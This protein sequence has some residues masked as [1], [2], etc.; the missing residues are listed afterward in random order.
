MTSWVSVSLGMKASLGVRHRESRSASTPEGPADGS[1]RGG[2][3]PDSIKGAP[4]V[5]TNPCFVGLE[6]PVLS[7]RIIGVARGIA[8]A[9]DGDDRRGL[10][11]SG[12]VP[13]RPLLPVHS[14][15]AGLMVLS[16]MVFSCLEWGSINP[17]LNTGQAHPVTA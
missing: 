15:P 12:D 16:A 3:A 9:Q 13:R 8:V 7:G 5:T 6:S 1:G 17:S 14:L 10:G 4:Q 11:Q 2:R